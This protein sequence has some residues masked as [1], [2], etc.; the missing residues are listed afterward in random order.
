MAGGTALPLLALLLLSPAW[1][2]REPSGGPAVKPE[3]ED[4]PVA[5]W[6]RLP[7][8]FLEDQKNIWTSPLRTSRS[9]AKWWVIF[10]T[11]T[12]ALIATDKTTSEGLPNSSDQIEVAKVASQVGASYT[13]FGLSGAAYLA[14]AWKK[15]DHLRETGFLTAEAVANAWVVDTALKAITRRERPTEGSGDG[16]FFKESG[17]IGESSFP[18]GHAMTVWAAASVVAHQYPHSI[19]VR[20]AAYGTAATVV[21]ARFAARKHFASDVVA[22]AA[23]GWFIGDYVFARRHNPALD[24]PRSR[25]RR[26]MSHVRIGIVLR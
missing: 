26:A 16:R 12:L 3:P 13:L 15:D 23:L 19:P 6:S 24:P 11:A 21:G 20:I 4:R 9:D 10:G 1:C 2:Q 25:L 8:Y 14:G 17:S 5:P 22:G 7:K 18:S